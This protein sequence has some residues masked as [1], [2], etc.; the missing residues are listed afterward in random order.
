MY[1]VN[2]LFGLSA[3]ATYT[4]RWPSFPRLDRSQRPPNCACSFCSARVSFD[5]WSS[6]CRAEAA[7]VI[8]R[9]L[10]MLHALYWCANEAG[11]AVEAGPEECI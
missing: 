6:I 11:R 4:P 3:A 9:P 5:A 2:P 10:M 1:R 8:L 7:L